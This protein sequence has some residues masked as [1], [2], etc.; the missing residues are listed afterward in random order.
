MAVEVTE[1][2]PREEAEAQVREAYVRGWEA[3]DDSRG[4]ALIASLAGMI[5]GGLAVG[6]AA[7]IALHLHH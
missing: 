5:M 2:V 7:L 4:S 6:V 3:A 1:W